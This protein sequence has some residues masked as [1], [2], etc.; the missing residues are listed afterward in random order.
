METDPGPHG[1]ATARETGHRQSRHRIDRDQQYPSWWQAPPAEWPNLPPGGCAAEIITN[2]AL[3]TMEIGRNRNTRYRHGGEFDPHSCCYVGASAEIRRAVL[4][5]RRFISTMAFCPPRAL[6]NPQSPIS[7][8]KQILPGAVSGSFFDRSFE[9]R[10]RA[11]ARVLNA[12]EVDCVVTDE[13]DNGR[14]FVSVG[15]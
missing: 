14:L 15:R 3:T 4:C 11:L 6:S 12:D 8:V 1:Q 9:I 13:G 7:R 2:S 10:Q 5:R